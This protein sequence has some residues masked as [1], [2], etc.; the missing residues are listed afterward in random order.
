VV[1]EVGVTIWEP[2]EVAVSFPIPWLM[3][4]V[5][6]RV[7]VQERVEREPGAI[8]EGDAPKVA[9]GARPLGVTLPEGEEEAEVPKAFVAVTMKV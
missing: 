2:V 4:T 6:A 5:E 9:V 7:V 8:R 1:V 3:E